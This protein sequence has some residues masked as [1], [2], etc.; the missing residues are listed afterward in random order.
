MASS[1]GSGRASG[2][3][4]GDRGSG[5]DAELLFDGLDQLHHFHQGLFG[6]RV[7]DLFVGKGHDVYLWKLSGVGFTR[8][9]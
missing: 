8:T 5:G 2:G 3:S 7:D 4:H 1:G 6:D 9:G